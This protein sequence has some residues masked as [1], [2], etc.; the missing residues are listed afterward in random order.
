MKLN[1]TGLVALAVDNWMSEHEDDVVSSI[2]VIVDDAMSEL[3]FSE[4]LSSSLRSHI[5]EVVAD[6]ACDAFGRIIE[7]A[8][9]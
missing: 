2:E 6:A 7:D 8:F 3:D 5:E 9:C 4:M 1:L